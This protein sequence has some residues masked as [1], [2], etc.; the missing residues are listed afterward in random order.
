MKLTL[1]LAVLV[2]GGTLKAD[3]IDALRAVGPEGNGAAAARAARDRLAA[4]GASN[5]VPV[6]KAF[7]GSSVLAQNWLR[8][9]F[10]AIADAEIKRG[11]YLP[12][13][14]LLAFIRDT[15]GAPEARRLAYEWLLK[16]TPELEQSLIPQLLQDPSPEFRRDAVKRLLSEASEA[17]GEQAV[18]LYQQALKGAVH[19]DQVTFVTKA[20]RE[21]GV[22]VDL[23][24]HFGFLTSWHIIG[25]F[26][27]KDRKG[28]PVAYPPESQID[29]TGSYDGQLGDVAWKSYSTDDDYGLMNIAEEI[30]NYKGSL[31]YATTT[32]QSTKPQ[33]V[34]FRLGTPNAWKLWVN[35]ELVFERE[36]YHRS[37]R[38]D[39]YRIPVSLKAGSNVIMLKVC[40]NEQD[41]SWAQRYQFQLR[42]CDATGSAI[43]AATQTAAT[44][45][46]GSN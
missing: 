1:V 36:E 13:D 30:E 20:L 17:T 16:R 7:D 18:A 38:M 23:Q 3:D 4:G 5:L 8:S 11:K 14:E 10:E 24:K 25:P 19:E 15:S 31:M 46:K 34:Q 12:K 21:A 42:V 44:T 22:D 40:Q 32:Y 6:L 41:D 39:Q 45:A 35:G 26:D 29:L 37:T 43:P 9:A 2:V 27:N 33:D 28:Y